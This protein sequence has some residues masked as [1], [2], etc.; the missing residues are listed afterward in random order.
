MARKP[1]AVGDLLWAKDRNRIENQ[2]ELFL[3]K[4]AY[5]DEDYSGNLHD[6]VVVYNIY[7]ASSHYYNYKDFRNIFKYR[8]VKKDASG[9]SDFER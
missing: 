6:V 7:R 4:E 8:M 3:V 9:R 5:I 1:F 2:E